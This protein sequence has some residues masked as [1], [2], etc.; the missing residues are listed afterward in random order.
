MSHQT[1]IKTKITD[2]EA[3]ASACE[4]LGLKL[5][6]NA[7]QRTYSGSVTR[8]LVIRCKG[9]YDIAAT[10]QQDGT[11]ELSTDWW[12]G[13]VEKE[14][15]KDYSVLTQ[16]YGIAKMTLEAES[17]GHYVERTTNEQGEPMLTITNN[18]W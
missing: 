16:E 18:N 13:Y 17:V 7:Q 6:H 12:Q 14:V 11:Y 15:G 2:E 4:Q 9:P 10:K 8:S 3:L 5:Q 1:V